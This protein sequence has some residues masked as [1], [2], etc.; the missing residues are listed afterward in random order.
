M[1]RNYIGKTTSIHLGYLGIGTWLHTTNLRSLCN[2]ISNS[3]GAFT[4][5]RPRFLGRSQ[6]RH[7]PVKTR[8]T[9]KAGTVLGGL[10]DL[11]TVPVPANT[12]QQ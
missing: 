8:E 6:S 3:N 5:A 10:A 7:K 9:V 12:T 2:I 11:Y 4:Y 1:V